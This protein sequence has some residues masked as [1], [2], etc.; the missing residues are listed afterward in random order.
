MLMHKPELKSEET[1]KVKTQMG[2]FSKGNKYSK[3]GEAPSSG[4]VVSL[5]CLQKPACKAQAS[6]EMAVQLGLA[7]LRLQSF[8]SLCG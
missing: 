3:A 5:C 8:L 6:E 2:Y 7:S 1:V 4:C